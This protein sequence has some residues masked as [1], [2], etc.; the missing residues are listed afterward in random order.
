MARW[1]LGF[2]ADYLLYSKTHNKAMRLGVSASQ[3]LRMALAQYLTMHPDD[4]E[5]EQ[6]ERKLYFPDK[7][8]ES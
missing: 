2:D 3:I 6:E 7:A 8:S 5:Q 4:A 1:K